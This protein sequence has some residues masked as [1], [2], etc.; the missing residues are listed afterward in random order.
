MKKAFELQMQR[1]LAL[2]GKCGLEKIQL[3]SVIL[4][5]RSDLS[6]ESTPPSTVSK[7]MLR[8]NVKT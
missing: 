4:H 5:T 8:L 1:G 3:F 7:E 2:T 6:L